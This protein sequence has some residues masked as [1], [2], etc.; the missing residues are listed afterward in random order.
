MENS[1][2]IGWE[3]IELAEIAGYQKGKKPKRMEPSP[4]DCSLVYLDIKAIEKGSN[5]I[6]VDR[7]S[8]NVTDENDLIIVWDGAR[9]GWVAKSRAGAIGSTIMALKPKI[10]KDYLLRFLQTQFNYI[11]SN[12]RGTGIPHV[13]PDIFWNIKV[14]IAPLKE[15][16]RIVAKLDAL[17]QKVESNKQH[18]E[19]IPIILK[20][21]RQS[22]LA[23]A[24]SGKLTEE[25]R[26]KNKK[27]ET[28][29]KLFERIQKVIDRKLA[30]EIALAKKRGT[31]KPKDQRTNKKA[32]FH[33]TELET[34]PDNWSYKRLED[35][36]FLVTDGTHHTPTYKAEGVKFLSVK[37][38]RPFKIRD[39]EIKFISV[40]EHNEINSRCNPERGDILYT[41]VGATFGYACVNNLEYPFSI[42][43]SLALIK[44]VYECINSKY[45]EAAMNSE[46]VFKQARERISGI[47]TPDLHLREPLN[48]ALNGRELFSGI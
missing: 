22:V 42:F 36:T 44:P 10:E 12:H 29:E 6:F 18:L 34:L 19:K 11:Q 43:V 13:D 8:S 40:A 31:R 23:A 17:M 35:I 14:P 4:F 1:L 7:E 41:K 32:D 45:L 30:E 28:G 33:E 21:F 39:E 24:V 9:A 38:V 5:E 20:R 37:N 46:T 47:G 3:E 48:T 25:W 26:K 2:P 27:V 16:N 15:Q